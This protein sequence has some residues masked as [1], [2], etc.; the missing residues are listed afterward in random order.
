MISFLNKTGLL[1]QLLNND[2]GIVSAIYAF[3]VI[4]ER[5][6]L[7]ASRHA[8]FQ[9]QMNS[10]RSK[11]LITAKSAVSDAILPVLPT[12]QVLHLRKKSKV[13]V[14]TILL[15]QDSVA[16]AELDSFYAEE[17]GNNNL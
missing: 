2:G 13:S 8:Q 15:E 10:Y 7:E 9:Q 17:G 12:A 3:H 6:E 4:R 11:A 5:A 1:N 16:H 14:D